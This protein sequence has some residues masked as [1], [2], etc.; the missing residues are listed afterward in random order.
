[1]NGRIV[2]FTYRLNSGDQVEILTGKELN[3]SRD[4][5]HSGLGYVHSSRA[6]AT[7]HSFF[8]KQDREK[9]QI[10]G[11]ELLERELQRA[12]L[13]T[14]ITLEIC[15]KFNLSH[16]DDLYAAVG[17]GDVRVMSVVH[18][19]QQLQ[20]PEKS[21]EELLPKP[22]SKSTLSPKKQSDSIVVQ[23]VGHLMTQIANCCKP[24]PG[25]AILGYITQ[26]RGVS[27]HKESCDQLQHLLSL[28]PERQIEVNWSEQVNVGFET[29]V[30]IFCYDRTGLLRD[31]TTVL[32][33][34]NVLLMGVNSV[35]DK[36]RQTATIAL[37]LEVNDHDALTRVMAKLRQL[38][39]VVDVKRRQG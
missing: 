4:W 21:E 39:D 18:Q 3:P 17:A 36:A 35:S 28:H 5:M 11:K 25:E 1:V 37:S 13:P 12:H 30:E 8:K 23:G 2:P 6:R 7:I 16:V 24:V 22:R 15:E 20:A 38:K 27:V 32:A 9:N 31:I 33:N 19:V 10:A 29:V 14:K 34:E 26:G